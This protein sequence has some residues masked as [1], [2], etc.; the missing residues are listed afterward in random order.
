MYFLYNKTL[1]KQIEQ[2]PFVIYSINHHCVAFWGGWEIWS[3]SDTGK[4]TGFIM[5]MHMCTPQMPLSSKPLHLCLFLTEDGEIHWGEFYTQLKKDCFLKKEA[6]DT[7]AA[8]QCLMARRERQAF[9]LV[10]S[11]HIP[12]KDI[13]Y[14]CV[15]QNVFFKKVNVDF[16][17]EKHTKDML[18]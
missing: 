10:E 15:K 13:C 2:T 14:L 17:Q 9:A 3:S 5:G 8:L 16:R 4:A 12:M 6:E 7:L 18:H 1:N 11:C